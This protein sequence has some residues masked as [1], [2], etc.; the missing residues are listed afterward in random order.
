M[1]R[2]GKREGEHT[3]IPMKV[4][5]LTLDA[6]NQAPILVL[7]QDG[8]SEILPIW[9]GATEALSI[10]VALNGTQL[11]RPLTHETMFQVIQALGAEVGGVD[12]MA[13]RDGTYY[14]ELEIVRGDNVV[15]VDC[16]P[17]DGVALAVRG[18][19]P[20]RVAGDVLAE[21][22]ASRTA[23]RGEDLITSFLPDVPSEQAAGN[24][25]QS[26]EPA[27]RYKM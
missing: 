15:R 6:E 2:L 3:M 27:S 18:N 4:L 14:A 21:T 11:D 7:Q 1:E 17:S 26:M 10:S 24:A 19:A 20:I 9:I 23:R 16:R 22:V 25:L 8:G 12:V 13:L 5:G